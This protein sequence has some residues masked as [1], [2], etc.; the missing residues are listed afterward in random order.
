MTTA[1]KI[2]QLREDKATKLKEMNTLVEGSEKENRAFNDDEKKKYEA[3]KGETSGINERIRVLEEQ[4]Q[5]ALET[6]TTINVNTRPQNHEGEKGEKR[7]AIEEWQWGKAIRSRLPGGKLDGVEAEMD[8][9]ER[10]AVMEGG[11]SE[12]HQNSV[13]APAGAMAR[14]MGR[15]IQRRDM[16]ATTATAAPNNEGS[17]TIQ[18]DVEGI[19]DVFL[20]EMVLGRLPVTRFNN[21]RGNVQF[22]QAQTLPSAGWAAT[23]NATATEKTPKLSKLNLSPKRLAAYI[24][25]SN[26]LLIQSESN[27]AEFA[28]NFLIR[29]S[30]I[31]FEKACYVGGGTGEPSGIL[32]STSNYTSVYA[33]GAAT[34]SV[35]AAGSK[36][37]WADMVNLV[38][39]PK[40]V[41]SPDG[42]AYIT[43]PKLM[44][45]LQITGRQSAGVEG[46]F[47]LPNW[48]S[49]V[50]GYPMYGTTNLP[51]TFSK[52][53][54][55][56]LSAIIFGDFR[57][58]TT[59]SW[60]G[61]E[62]GIDPY[63]NMKE[64]LTNIVLNSYV[65]CGVLNPNAFAAG[66][67][68]QWYN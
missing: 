3:L 51:D 37:V 4:E 65:D 7:A 50:N 24:Q 19:V 42:Q 62:I 27:I 5:R 20:P 30:A 2:K 56:V 67:D 6:V 63:V 39:G 8:K 66:K 38:A 45:R 49:G 47:I 18:T 57:S 23:E 25:M 34:N 12:F 58:F 41:N 53:G 64:A 10:K 68:F 28:R 31:E 40:G 46:N 21:L 13:M 1:E 35:N 16:D 59:A 17:F 14:T 11:Y 22:P 29:A 32:S 26:Q 15:R 36:P 52:G 33:G 61:M 44:A 43:S 9:E 60:G 55:V 54:S 48:N